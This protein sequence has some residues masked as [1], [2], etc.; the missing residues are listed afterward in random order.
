M[1]EDKPQ[2]IRF[3]IYELN[4][5]ERT[6]LRKGVRLRLQ[7]KPFALLVLLLQN[8]GQLVDRVELRRR[9][10]PTGTNV[11]FEH[12]IRVAIHKLRAALDDTAD[13]PR[14]IETIPG[15]GYRFVASVTHYQSKNQNDCPTVV[16]L[17]VVGLAAG[18]EI[19]HIADGFTEE[20]TAQL[21]NAKPRQLS[22]IGRT[23]AMCYKGASKSIATIGNEIGVDYVLEASVRTHQGILR[24]TA[25]LIKVSDQSHIWTG[26]VQGN[27]S[28]PVEAQITL[29]EQIVRGLTLYLFPSEPFLQIASG[30]QSEAE[31]LRQF[32][33]GGRFRR[34]RRRVFSIPR[35]TSRLVHRLFAPTSRRLRRFKAKTRLPG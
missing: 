29:S 34:Y 9:L 14:F 22:V 13:C 7:D 31:A 8:S 35:V 27:S 20:L 6:L 32:H 2:W 26:S 25:Q 18:A 5:E 4:I 21:S 15:H 3:S 17:P 19:G 33:Q 12:G 24:L 1:T 23:T 11:D 28:N 30:L 16:V 10:W